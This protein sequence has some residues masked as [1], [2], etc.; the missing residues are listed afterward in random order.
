LHVV[1]DAVGTGSAA[2]PY[3]EMRS[4]PPATG[5]GEQ[6]SESVR[7]WSAVLFR[8]GYRAHAQPNRAITP[9]SV[10]RP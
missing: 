9:L 4:V 2:P 10:I 6:Q 1:R 3:A 8:G 7:S 5:L